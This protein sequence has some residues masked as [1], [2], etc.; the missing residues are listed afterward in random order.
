M[1]ARGVCDFIRGAAYR[2][3]RVEA[4]EVEMGNSSAGSGSAWG[5]EKDRS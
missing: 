2:E 4:S 1:A 3:I 5:K